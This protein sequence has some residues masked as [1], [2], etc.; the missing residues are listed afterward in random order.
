MS[1]SFYVL[2][3]NR[4]FCLLSL[5]NNL[6]RRGYICES[7]LFYAN[8]SVTCIFLARGIYTDKPIA[9]N[10]F[11]DYLPPPRRLCFHRRQLV[12]LL[13]GS[14]KNNRFSQNSVKRWRMRK[15]RYHCDGNP[16][17]REIFKQNFFSTLGHC[18]TPDT[19]NLCYMRDSGNYLHQV[20]S[21]MIYIWALVDPRGNPSMHNP[22]MHLIWSVNGALAPAGK[23][24]CMGWL[25]IGHCGVGEKCL[26]FHGKN[27]VQMI[28]Y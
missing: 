4:K 11:D 6:F 8:A 2:I 25:A 5:L 17:L 13:A 27:T 20:A 28:Q 21:Y 12:C 14:P 22:S 24:F 9:T 26:A 16:E 7:G 15:W 18:H 1:G 19:M 23:I 3:S 10:A